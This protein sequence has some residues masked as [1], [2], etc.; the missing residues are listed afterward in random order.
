MVRILQRAGFRELRQ[1]GSHSIFGKGHRRAIVPLHGG[2]LKP[3]TLRAILEA[4]ELSVEDL[5][6]LS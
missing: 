5:H 3:G 4:A 1:R 6:R 2:D